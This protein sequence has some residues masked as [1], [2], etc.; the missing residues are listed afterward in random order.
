M[1][2][3]YVHGYDPRESLRLQDQAST[4]AELLHA[5]TAYPAGSRIL[6]AGCGVGA[7]TVTLAR[8]S[9][10][11]SITSID[12]SD[13]SVA[14]AR[15]AV[16]AAGLGNVAFRQADIFDLP[17]ALQSFDHVF[18]CFVLEHLAQPVEA[19]HALKR[20]LK[21]GGTITV[22]E[23][24]H[25][26]AYFHPDSASARQAIGCQVELQA[27]AGGDA[28]IGRKLYPLLREAGFDAVRVSPRMVY[29][30]ASKPEL[31]EGFTRKTFT[32][33]IEGVRASAL[34]AGLI[35]APT[36]DRGIADLHRTAEEDGVFCYTF[37]KA[38]ALRR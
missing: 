37:F 15:K 36:F 23:G 30:D 25:G 18:L 33:M 4:L 21:R 12:I 8:N 31:V 13:A 28:L 34:S 27:R 29:A 22:I 10:G 24:D 38:A 17:F 19:L 14:E 26:S 11:A 1:S 2:D 7:Q 9:P 20:A 6:E 35:D 16:E 32:A 3:K 5:D